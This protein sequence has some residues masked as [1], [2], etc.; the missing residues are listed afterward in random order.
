MSMKPCELTGQRFGR[1]TVLRRD[2][3]NAYGKSMWLCQCDCGNLHRVVSAC[4]KN[5]KVRSCGCLGL[6]TKS[7]NGRGNRTH[8]RMPKGLYVSWHDMICRCMN[9]SHKSYLNYGGRGIGICEEWRNSYEFFRDWAFAHGW[10]E[11]LTLDRID[12]NGNYEPTNCRWATRKE[13]ANNR[14]TNLWY[15]ERLALEVSV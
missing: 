12:P 11:G 3:S 6:E 7:E 9:T 10:S 4:L 5:S 14:R 15:K 2:G 8:G 1:L 13:Q